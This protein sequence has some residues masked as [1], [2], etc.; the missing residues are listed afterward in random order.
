M[1]SIPDTGSLSSRA[2]IRYFSSSTFP[3]KFGSAASTA[4]VKWHITYNG[5]RFV[6][7]SSILNAFIPRHLPTFSAR[8]P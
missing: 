8:L 7:Y 5:K 6:R 1:A 4:S 2:R 3:T